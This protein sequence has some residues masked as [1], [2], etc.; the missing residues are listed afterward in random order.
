[1]F[2]VLTPG[3]PAPAKAEAVES[4]TLVAA[5]PEDTPP[6]AYWDRTKDE[7]SGFSVDA[8]NY[9]AG[10][11]G[12]SVKYIVRKN[13]V[14]AIRAV[15]DG[16][17]DVAPNLGVTEERKKILA[18]TLPLESENMALFVRADSSIE[19]FYPGMKIGARKGGSA[20][21]LFRGRFGDGG[22]IF[23]DNSFNGFFALLAGHIDAYLAP[24]PNFIQLARNAG[25]EDKI[26][27]AGPPI[28]ELKRAIGLRKADTELREDLDKAVEKFVASADYRRIYA[29]WYSKPGQYWTAWRVGVVAAIFLVFVVI[30]MAGWRYLS[31]VRL[32]R[33]LSRTI[34]ERKSA[35]AKLR[36][37]EE[38]FRRMFDQSADAIIIVGLDGG[39]VGSNAIACQR[40][41][42]SRDELL[43][44]TV[45]QLD[46]QVYAGKALEQIEKLRKYGIWTFEVD[47]LA[48][49]GT[50]IPTEVN[51]RL[52]MGS[53]GPLFLSSCRDISKRRQ[54]EEALRESEERF[55]DAAAALCDARECLDVILRSIGCGVIITDAGLVV[56]R[57]NEAGEDITGWPNDEAAGKALSLVFSTLDTESGEADDHIADRLMRG[58]P[59][60]DFGRKTAL[61]R[62]DGTEIDVS[63]NAA[64]LTDCQGDMTGSVLVIRDMS[65]Q[66]LADRLY[67]A[68]AHE[69]EKCV[70]I[71]AP[72]KGG[73]D[74]GPGGACGRALVMDDERMIREVAGGLLKRMGYEVCYASDGNEAV[75]M[76]MEALKEGRPFAFVIMDLIIPGGMGGD[77]A[78][79]KLLGL[80][81]DAR[82][83][84]SSGYANDPMM[85][86]YA[87]CGFRAAI[88]KPY[89]FASFKEMVDRVAAGQ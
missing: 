20:K 42:Y 40:Y 65:A 21:D 64:C 54:V 9:V 30:F 66:R 52:I 31:V 62:R 59:V 74:V 89:R 1:M 60:S 88:C 85:S 16:E 47:H 35:E 23:Y 33:S 37:S 51:S 44:M 68:G 12:Y 8:L 43:G 87:A 11:A 26:R 45:M 4:R 69:P 71:K 19:G 81:P 3:S 34:E 53:E 55:R 49:D 29:K 10:R 13:W 50:V 79:R 25:L 73:R 67:S 56:R 6:S 77:E 22:L 2:V 7:A 58:G 28:L 72:L 36:E 75:E 76:F 17:A 5:I 86:D 24:A 38:N 78:G 32:N 57:V 70:N 48:K 14:E 46:S 84:I 80:A 15:V 41:Q 82:V 63:Y 83:I 61:V 27:I 39:I 18:F